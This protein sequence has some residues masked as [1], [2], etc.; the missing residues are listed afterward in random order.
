M[1]PDVHDAEQHAAADTQQRRCA[2]CRVPLS[3]HVG[4]RDTWEARC[5]LRMQMLAHSVT[6]RGNC[7]RG[8]LGLLVSAST[9]GTPEVV[10]AQQTKSPHHIGILLN[11]YQP[12]QRDPQAFREGLQD[13][14][15]V[16]GRDIVF[17]WRTAS[18]DYRRLPELAGDL[19]QRSVEVIVVDSTPAAR[20]AMHAPDSVQAAIQQG[21]RPRL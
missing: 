1:Y 21:P 17:E 11:A 19:V 4:R 16:E 12:G 15:Y 18:G 2:C 14:G 10:C 3:V 7:L 8:L 5:P 9:L 13:A 6:E 20:A